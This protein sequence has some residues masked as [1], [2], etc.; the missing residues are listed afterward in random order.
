MTVSLKQSLLCTLCSV[1]TLTFGLHALAQSQEDYELPPINYSTTPP[2]DVIT[3]LQKRLESGELKFSGTDKEIVSALLRELHIPP[4]SQLLVFSKTSFQRERIGP[5]RPRALYF[6]DTSYVGWVPGGLIEVT[7]IDPS[8]GPIFYSFD[9][10]ADTSKLKHGFTREMDCL[11][12]HGGTFVSHIPAVFARSVFPDAD[13][14]P[15]LRQG[16]QVVDFRTPF[17]ERWGGW[18]VT[19]RHGKALH[20][21]NVICA[22]KDSSLVADFAHGANITNLSTLCSTEKYLKN[23]SDIVALMVFEHQLAMHNAITRAMLNCRR[24]LNYQKGLQQAFKEPI[25]EEPAY[26]SVKTVFDS[27]TREIVNCLLFKDEAVLPEG[28]EG[29]AEF[30]KVFVAEGASVPGVGSLKEFSLDGHLFRNRC[31]YL[32]YSE[33]F[34]ALPD[35]LKRRIYS[36][37]AKALHPTNSDPAYAYIGADERQRIAQIL[38]ATHPEL[39]HFL[40]LSAAP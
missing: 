3:S 21:G 7:A 15:L 26:D 18:Y 37:L 36:R 14:E 16:T 9:P 28:L 11:R 5:E 22:E 8:L 39:K 24:M 40:E 19:G 6:S 4:E 38:R 13:G 12:C 34:R 2:K 1:L 29:S 32:I 35:A 30:Q 33:S 10:R 20:R 31:S 23:T 27:S 17:E 25:T